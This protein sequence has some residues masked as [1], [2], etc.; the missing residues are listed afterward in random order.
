MIMKKYFIFAAIAAAGLLTSCSSSDDIVANDVPE[1]PTVNEGDLVP[2]KLNVAQYGTVTRGTGTVGG[3]IKEADPTTAVGN[4]GETTNPIAN[5]WQGQ[6][7]NVYM[8]KTFDTRTTPATAM[9]ILKVAQF[10]N[11]EGILADIYRDAELTTPKGAATGTASYLTGNTATEDANGG[12]IDPAAPTRYV[13]YYPMTDRF[14]FW[15]YR[16]DTDTKTLNWKKVENNADVAATEGTDAT[17]LTVTF[18]IDG[19]QDVLAAVT[20]ARTWETTTKANFGNDE[21]VYNAAVA[22]KYS[23]S[24][25]RKGLDPELSFAHKLTRLTFEGQ[26]GDNESQTVYVRGIKVRP[27]KEYANGDSTW[28]SRKGLELTI[29]DIANPTLQ[30]IAIQEITTTKNDSW[31]AGSDNAN[32][33]SDS[34]FTLM[35]RAV[36]DTEG[37]QNLVALFDQAAFDALP[38]ANKT[39]ANLG[40]NGAVA[41]AGTWDADPA[42][43]TWASIGESI[44]LP[45]APS[46]EVEILLAQVNV[47]EE[48]ADNNATPVKR[49]VIQYKT[50][51]EVVRAAT[52][53]PAT[54]PAFEA[55]YTYDFKIK[56]YGLQRIDIATT[57]EAWKFGENV[58]VD[59]DN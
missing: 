22:A 49:E 6:K 10:E 43:R 11:P 47:V 23:A 45:P 42:N 37:N 33:K 51:K 28:Y 24:S 8:F 12:A 27:L 1:V 4:D 48:T 15:G 13:K 19:T 39:A 26:A 52:G 31:Q 50:L 40:A 14:D 38:A 32:N 34:Q 36:G 16:I 9:N 57:L 59:T 5:V 41:M 56:V 7:V 30:P 54:S 20:T 35:K 29:A 44:I 17:K 53:T 58:D 25:A 3:V 2:I 18:D 46:Y 55:A 21:D